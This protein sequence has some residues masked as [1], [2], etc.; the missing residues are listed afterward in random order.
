MH[1]TRSNLDASH[2]ATR[3]Y[4]D[5]YWYDCNCPHEQGTAPS[6]KL[7]VRVRQHNHALDLGSDEVWRDADESGPGEDSHP[8]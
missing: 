3:K 5:D 7:I 6:H 2:N 8:T 4:I 1:D